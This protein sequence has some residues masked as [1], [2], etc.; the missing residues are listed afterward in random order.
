VDG[1]DPGEPPLILSP[2]ANRLYLT[3]ASS[4]LGGVLLKAKPAGGVTRLYWFC[5]EAFL[6]STA[7]AEGLPWEPV[8]GRRK[9]RV[10]DDHGRAASVEV[11]VE[12]D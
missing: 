8:P 6:G 4:E 5:D 9:I 3:G 1:L 10:V 11:R 12:R 2:L 7:A